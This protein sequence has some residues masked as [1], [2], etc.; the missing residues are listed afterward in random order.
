MKSIFT[1]TLALLL[2]SA[3][4]IAQTIIRGPYLQNPTSTSITVMWR[5][6]A[7]SSSKVFY[8]TDPQNLTQFVEDAT[9]VADHKV[10][11]SGLQPFTKYYYSVGTTTQVL[12]GPDSKHHF[13]TSVVPGSYDQKVRIW[14][15][16][17]FGKA[18]TEEKDVMESFLDY[19]A[20]TLVNAWIWL[21]D[22][23]Y[24][25]GKDDEYQTKVF[26]TTYYGKVMPYMPFMPCPGNH[27]YGVISP[28]QNSSDPNTHSGPYYDMIDVPINGEA[29]GGV[30]SGKKLYYSFDYGHVHFLSL[31][32]ELGAP[33]S[34]SDDWIGANPFGNFNGSPFTDWIE[35][36]LAANTQPWV[37]AYFHQPAHT[38]G[39]HLSSDAWE[40]YMK[41]M[42][43]NIVPI[44]EEHN[45]DIIINGH[46]HVY[47]RSVLMHGFYDVPS[48]W[49]STY[50]VDG[51]SGSKAQGE[52]YVKNAGT[53][54]TVYIVQGNSASKTTDPPLDHPAMYYSHGCDTCVGST[55]IEVDKKELRSR[56]L[57]AQGEILDDFTIIKP[58]IEIG[59]NEKPSVFADVQV[60]PNPFSGLTT[61]SYTLE[62]KQKLSVELFDITGKSVAVLY[63]G[64]KNSGSHTMEINGDKLQLTKGNYILKLSSET[65]SYSEKLLKIK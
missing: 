35:A 49:N 48:Q 46:S 25:D 61:L 52:A 15:I 7:P 36:D 33:L 3:N 59:V 43:E 45:V 9:T 22:N 26:D 44:L 13:T 32:S 60:Y 31:N 64:S 47:E 11:V 6:D 37:I 54:G 2:V 10:S 8:G 29:G 39:S 55:I 50:V 38:A 19:N 4:S 57:T 58:D 24:D 62:A 14:A 53:Q 28:P 20:D 1:I 18:N 21:G 12:S 5:T 16:G 40:V 41:A 63:E 27:D 42:R 56:Y 17:D 30:A 23:V 34:S 65:G 51:S